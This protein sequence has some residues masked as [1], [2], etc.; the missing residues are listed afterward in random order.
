MRRA[1]T[2]VELMLAVLIL[3]ILTIISTWTFH[4]VVRNWTLSTEMADNVQRTDYALAQITSAL[5]SAYF[6]TSGEASDADGFQLE[7]YN[8]RNEPDNSDMIA[9]TKLG[10]AIVGRNSRFAKSA[11][12]ITMYVVEPGK[13]D[14][15]EYENGGLVC[16]VIGEKKFRPEDFD[17]DDLEN[18]D[19]F[20]LSENVQGFNCRVL[21]KD[22][23]FKDDQ[24]NWQDKWDTS[25]CIP[26]RVQLTFWMKPI[27]KNKEPYPIVR[28]V[29]IPL[30]EVSQNPVKT[31]S[32]GTEDKNNKD[33]RN[34]GKGTGNKGGTQQGGKNGGGGTSSGGGGGMEPGGGGSSRGGGMS[35]GGMRG[36]GMQGGGMRGGGMSGGGG[37]PPG[38]GMIR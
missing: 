32:A 24:A 16:D 30:W 26:R 2:I 5:R 10:P 34:G 3:S 11:H 9:W 37:L 18:W 21:D 17:E 4:T 6:P 28:V 7:N 23:P 27:D 13:S 29:E 15:E 8:E 25:N 36:G 20:V 19:H 31:D 35:G 38:G 1:F 14:V 22:Q 12:H 33:R